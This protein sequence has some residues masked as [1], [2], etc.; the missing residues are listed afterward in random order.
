MGRH[1]FLHLLLSPLAA[2]SDSMVTVPGPE[3]CPQEP[4][5]PAHEL[6]K[7][8]GLQLSPQHVCGSV[9]CGTGRVLGGE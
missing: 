3:L 9:V 8:T 6:D 2:E 5:S 7:A 4:C 1:A